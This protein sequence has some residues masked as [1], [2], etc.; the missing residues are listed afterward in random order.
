MLSL[1]ENHMRLPA[2]L[3]PVP[4]RRDA[5]TED[6]ATQKC[7]QLRAGPEPDSFAS[8]RHPRPVSQ[9]NGLEGPWHTLTHFACHGE[10]PALSGEL[11]CR[12]AELRAQITQRLDKRERERGWW[13]WWGPDSCHFYP[14]SSPTGVLRD[15]HGAGVHRRGCGSLS[16]HAGRRFLLRWQVG[17]AHRA[18]QQHPPSAPPLV[19]SSRYLRTEAEGGTVRCA[20]MCFCT[21]SLL[22]FRL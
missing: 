18:R 10:C 9:R 22:I 1:P 19:I 7:A 13:W 6:A 15:D 11:C 4:R 21:K 2:L 14:G 3:S 20:C 16:E 8:S 12:A 5:H 17:F